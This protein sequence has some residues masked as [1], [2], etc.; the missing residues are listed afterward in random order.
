VY[1]AE[2]RPEEEG[3][4]R[5]AVVNYYNTAFSE[6]YQSINGEAPDVNRILSAYDENSIS[7]QYQYAAKNTHPINAKDLLYG[8]PK[9]ETEYSDA[10]GKFHDYARSIQNQL[11]ATDLLLVDASTGFITYSIK[12]G[13]ILEPHY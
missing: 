2:G 10:H 1:N 5:N 11:G 9:D 12:K 13:L 4:I 7:L 6:H 8:I 3:V